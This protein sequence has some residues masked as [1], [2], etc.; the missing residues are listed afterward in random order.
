M[1]LIPSK[2]SEGMFYPLKFDPVYKEIIWGGRNIERH[3]KR[4][5]PPGNIA[6]S[7]ELCCREDGMSI[8][9]NGIFKSKSLHDLIEEHGE[10]IL[11]TRVCEKY[12]LNFPLLIKIIDANDKLSVQVHPD[13]RYAHTIGERNGKSEM[14]YILD[15]K[16]DARLIYGL[17][18][19]MTKEKFIDAIRNGK[20][21]DTLNQ[22]PVKTGDFLY[23]PAGTVH[24]ILDGILIAEIQQNSN[25]TFRIY[26]YDRIDANGKKRQLHVDRALDVIN[27]D[28]DNSPN[29]AEVTYDGNNSIKGILKSDY[30]CTD[31]ISI[32]DQYNS[33]TDGTSFISMIIIEGCGE[34]ISG[35]ISEKIVSGETLL[36]PA[37]LGSYII[38]GNLKLLTS[39]IL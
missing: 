28:F 31:E 17:K 26:D 1:Q 35:G 24:A 25:T 23:I 16:K 21:Y 11:G 7:W 10:K 3:F 18:K 36:L 34:I 9:N 39:Y 4:N 15:A 8:V 29:T 14:W 13:D 30:F 2:E 20:V 38:K 12:G 19:G 6:E 27:F 32:K 33:A 22:I 5:I 37:A